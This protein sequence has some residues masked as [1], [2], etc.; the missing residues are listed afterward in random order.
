MKLLFVS[1]LHSHY[2]KNTLYIGLKKLFGTSI[3]IYPEPYIDKKNFKVQYSNKSFA[4]IDKI[5]HNLNNYDYIIIGWLHRYT[6]NIIKYIL[7]NNNKRNIIIIDLDDLPYIR[8]I[9]SNRNVVAYFK[10]EKLIKSIDSYVYIKKHFPAMVYHNLKTLINGLKNYVWFYDMYLYPSFINNKK[11]YPIP[12]GVSNLIE[13]YP[14]LKNIKQKKYD[15]S[16]IATPNTKE[17]KVIFEILKNIEKKYGIN[18]YINKGSLNFREYLKVIASS[19]ISINTYGYGVDTFRYYEIPYLNSML[20]TKK[21]IIEIPYNF[22]NGKSAVFYKDVV[23]IEDLIIEYLE[24]NKWKKI[25]KNGNIHVKKHFVD[26]KLAEYFI[27]LID[28]FQ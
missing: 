9:I 3:D 23:E 25:S 17:R 20:L 15:V 19:K 4:N 6:E 28:E 24:N 5:K 27:N 22:I 8:K 12:L 1:L 14:K 21:P 2:L 13:Y 11:V 7:N 26:I 16:F 10:R 18:C